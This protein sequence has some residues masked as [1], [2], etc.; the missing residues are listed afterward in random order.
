MRGIRKDE[1]LAATSVDWLCI[2]ILRQIAETCIAA[3]YG[4]N[5][6]SPEIDYMVIDYLQ[7][8]VPGRC[9]GDTSLCV[10]MSIL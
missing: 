8:C 7:Y 3:L 9:A 5:I 10:D 2:H 1:Y 6:K 4:E